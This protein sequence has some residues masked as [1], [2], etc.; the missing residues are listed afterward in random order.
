MI[1]NL[2]ISAL[3]AICATSAANAITL[4]YEITNEET[5]TCKITGWTGDAPTGA[6]TIPSAASINGVTYTI[7]NIAPHALDNMPEVTQINI[8][9][10]IIVIGDCGG[11]NGVVASI[12]NFNGFPKLQ[13]FAVKAE[14]TRFKNDGLG[15]L[16]TNTDILARVPQ[17]VFFT[18]NSF[19][20]QYAYVIPEAFTENSKIGSLTITGN[21]KF[22]ENPGFNTMKGLTT[23]VTTKSDAKMKAVDGILY[24]QDGSVLNYCP[25]RKML[26]SLAVPSAVKELGDY[27]LAGCIYLSNI[28][29]YPQPLTV[30]KAAFAGS[31]IQS[32]I[33][34][35]G[36]TFN[37]DGYTFYKCASLQTITFNGSIDVL[38][39]H[40]ASDCKK[41]TTV[42]YRKN[43]PIQLCSGAFKNCTSLVNYPFSA[44]YCCNYDSV[45]ANIGV[46]DLVFNGAAPCDQHMGYSAGWYTFTDCANIT[47]AN[48]MNIDNST[49]Q[50]TISNHFIY[51]CPNFKE[52]YLPRFT[53]FSNSLAS[54]DFYFGNPCN[55][56]KIAFGSYT[57]VNTEPIFV[58]S[59]NQTFEP[60]IYMRKDLNGRGK[61]YRLAPAFELK[62]GAKLKPEFFFE[63]MTP[64]ED[65]LYSGATYYV[66]P[67][68]YN[69]YREVLKV[70][71]TL[72]EMISLQVLVQ[73]NAVAFMVASNLSGRVVINKVTVNDDKS[74]ANPAASV[75]S[76]E[77]AKA[78]FK[79]IKIDYAVDGVPFE[80]TYTNEDFSA[81]G[82]EVIEADADAITPEYFDLQ[83]RRVINPVKGRLYLEQRGS[84]TSKIVF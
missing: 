16:V 10:S 84:E 7:T 33:F 13:K 62:N 15:C 23:F 68:A 24:S 77:L 1:K 83:G 49:H 27:A 55:L 78:D 41:L 11:I 46:T 81:T 28:S 82:I 9:A 61:Y 75:I 63:T 26:S 57:V 80:N 47:R 59:G 37:E 36:T 32:I 31:G 6:W 5:K 64:P 38:P 42:Q 3:A 69:N 8:P 17:A 30:G 4:S 18:A 76:T 12:K 39:K 21:E 50:F 67:M 35:E 74:W 52:L 53:N 20:L 44:S 73:N 56:E 60:T 70:K 22:Y 79:T 48:F 66:P 43:S 40:F 51:N 2:L 34:P 19:I 29:F 25:P 14:N 65:Y 71:G 45:F 72:K 58:Y 54:E